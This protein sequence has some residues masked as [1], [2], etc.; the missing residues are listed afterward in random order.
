MWS[1]MSTKI[2][3]EITKKSKYYIPKHRYYEL[4]HFVQ[5]YPDW[6][7]AIR[8]LDGL[9]RRPVDYVCSNDISDPVYRAAEK[10]EELQRRIKIITDVA[11]Q[12]DKTIGIYILTAIINNESYDKI[13]A[14]S[15]I[16]CCREVYYE[17]YRKF[18]FLLDIA[19]K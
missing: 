15:N 7:K 2:R 4:K 10:R 6:V 16:P 11:N 19:R 12:T 17:L 9:S 13:N 8:E 1:L 5:Q 18:F 14:R 3:P